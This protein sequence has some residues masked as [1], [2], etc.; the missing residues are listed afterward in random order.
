MEIRGQQAAFTIVTGKGVRSG[1]P[2]IEVQGTF[3]GKTGPAMLLLDADA[4]RLPEGEVLKM[5]DSIR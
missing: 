4:T 2:R 5:L 3:Q 1:V